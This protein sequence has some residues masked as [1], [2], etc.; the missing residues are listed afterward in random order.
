MD[1]NKIIN[2]ES[3]QWADNVD[4]KPYGLDGQG[5]VHV[6]QYADG[7]K[8]IEVY[9]YGV[10][11][12]L[13]TIESVD[14]E[15]QKNFGRTSQTQADQAER[16]VASRKLETNPETG[17]PAWHVTYRDGSEVWDEKDVPASSSTKDAPGEKTTL[18]NGEMV[19]RQIEPDG[20]QGRIL[21]QRP[22]TQAEIDAI[23]GAKPTEAKRRVPVE[24]RP[25]VF[26][27][28]TARKDANGNT[29]E[30][31]TY[32][33]ADGNPVTT[34][35]KPLGSLPADTHLG[36]VTRAVQAKLDEIYA[37]PNLTEKEK[38]DRATLMVNAGDALLKET[39]SILTAQQTAFSNETTLRGQDLAETQSR[40][41]FSQNVWDTAYK[42]AVEL[43]KYQPAGSDTGFQAMLGQMLLGSGFA[44]ANGG[45]RDVARPAMPQGLQQAQ[46]LGL[47]GMPAI[48]INVGTAAPPS[49]QAAT[50]LPPA[51]PPAPP[52]PN[53]S[54][55]L[56]N[57]APESP[58]AMDP[59][60]QYPAWLH[61]MMAA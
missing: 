31:T 4:L 20:S 25:G 8:V 51:P 28:T 1:P 34:A 30:D 52:M 27:V 55:V 16:Q 60:A 12:A 46:G 18:E 40:R 35:A 53:P 5:F 33:D 3:G 57:P 29:V 11:G 45:M 23:K 49:V 58:D 21:K 36:T 6:I 48:N 56:P 15:I 32:E 14:P 17:R 59:N 2:G 44:A 50:Q 26:K 61:G 38:L 24:G 54:P 7:R 47:P 22:A 42:Q 41:N 39:Q 37:D 19:T 9:K 10:E 13:K 43:N